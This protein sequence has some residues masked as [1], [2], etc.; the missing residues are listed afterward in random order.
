MFVAHDK[1]DEELGTLA[2]VQAEVEDIEE[3]H[4]EP[5]VGASNWKLASVAIVIGAL[6]LGS[7]YLFS[8]TPPK[9][10]EILSATDSKKIDN[11]PVEGV[12]QQPDVV[13]LKSVKILPLAQRTVLLVKKNPVT[14]SLEMALRQLMCRL[15][16]TFLQLG[17]FAL[18]ECFSGRFFAW[19]LFCSASSL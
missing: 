17:G 4:E 11:L 14:A 10:R 7:I 3:K 15:E 13:T 6:L 1:R 19:L 16:M 9:S 8:G 12:N 18:R 5:S 2:A